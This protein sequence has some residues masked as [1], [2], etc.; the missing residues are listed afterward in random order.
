MNTEALKALLDKKTLSSA[1][2]SKINKAYQSKFGR[3][4][5][6]GNCSDCYRDAVIELM[7]SAQT[8]ERLR[9]G[10]VINYNGVLYNRKSYP[11]PE[12]LI[13]IH[14]DKLEIK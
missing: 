10:I 3:K 5:T 4:P 9:A 14:R 13:A 6:A 11:L 7:V 12:E 8:G 1:D 2:K